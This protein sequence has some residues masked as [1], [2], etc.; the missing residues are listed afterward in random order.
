MLGGASQTVSKIRENVTVHNRQLACRAL[1][2]APSLNARR[3]IARGRLETERLRR[4]RSSC[5]RASLRCCCSGLCARFQQE[6]GEQRKVR[7]RLTGVIVDFVDRRQQQ[8][9]EEGAR[10]GGDGAELLNAAPHRYPH[11]VHFVP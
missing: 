5:G 9:H 10:V 11:R 1:N 6:I 2:D 8:P 4:L 3:E 7:R